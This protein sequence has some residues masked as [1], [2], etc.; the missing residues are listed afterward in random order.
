MENIA[1]ATLELGQAEREIDVADGQCGPVPPGV[2]DGDQNAEQWFPV[3][4]SRQRVGKQ[5]GMAAGVGQ[6]DSREAPFGSE[7]AGG[8]TK[9]QS[10]LRPSLEQ[11]STSGAPWQRLGRQFGMAAGADQADGREA[12]FGREVADGLARPQPTEGHGNRKT[13]V[14]CNDRGIGPDSSRSTG[15]QVN[16]SDHTYW[17]WESVFHT[18]ESG[19]C[20]RKHAEAMVTPQ[21]RKVRQAEINEYVSHLQNGTFGPALEPNQY[22]P[23]PAL[24]AV[25]VYS[26]S[27]KDLGAYKARVVIQ[28]FLMQQGLH[29]NDVH[30]PV[31]A[32]TT[33][34]VFM[35]GVAVQGR[36]LEHWDVKTAFLTT[37]MDCQIDVTL[38]EAF[39]SD[40][41]LQPNAR[42]R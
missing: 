10:Q 22:A 7:V 41:D 15:D 31:P 26:R 37:R 1:H 40:E 29:Y 34:R 3:G 28:G 17:F 11:R 16:T 14:L 38:P 19:P 13:I 36:V 42:P 30:A 23:G 5:F 39:N 20:P 35:L 32:V 33:F 8:W 18:T 12:P 25:W 24:K 4:A 6:T 2:S 27:K 9:P 21:A